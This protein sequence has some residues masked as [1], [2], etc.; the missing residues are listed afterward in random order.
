MLLFFSFFFLSPVISS[1]II[2]YYLIILSV[3]RFTCLFSLFIGSL[4]L[5]PGLYVF[6]NWFLHV[7]FYMSYFFSSLPYLQSLLATCLIA[8][9][10]AAVSKPSYL[11]WCSVCEFL[12]I[13]SSEM[14]LPFCLC[15][16]LMAEYY[17][18]H[19]S[20]AWWDEGGREEVLR[21]CQIKPGHLGTTV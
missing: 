15:A 10:W 12:L 20:L 6:P 2:F 5:F 9:N 16:G 8:F 3:L 13:L 18:L 1:F 4:L 19:F 7:S 14:S 17:S 21:W 11:Q